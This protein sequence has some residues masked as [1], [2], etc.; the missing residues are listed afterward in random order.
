MN[1]KDIAAIKLGS[2]AFTKK[3]WQ[4]HRGILAMGSGV[5]KALDDWQRYCPA[6]P[7]LIDGVAEVEV[8]TETC[9]RLKAAL[10]RAKKKCGKL[11]K[12]TGLAC[13]AYIAEIDKYMPKLGLG[14]TE[15]SD[16]AAIWK[17]ILVAM[18]KAIGAMV[19]M[20][21]R[22]DETL[23]ALGKLEETA[24]Y[25]VTRAKARNMMPLSAREDLE[26]AVKELRA[27]WG[28]A[29][30]FTNREAAGITRLADPVLDLEGQLKTRR[31][32]KDMRALRD[33][34]VK[35]GRKEGAL[36]DR[37]TEVHLRIQDAEAL[38]SQSQ[39]TVQR[40]KDTLEQYM[41]R[42]W[43]S[44]VGSATELN[45]TIQDLTARLAKIVKANVASLDEGAKRDLSAEMRSIDD[46]RLQLDSNVTNL[47]NIV[48]TAANDTKA[49]A[50]DKEIQAKIKEMIAAHKMIATQAKKLDAVIRA[51]SQKVAQM[52]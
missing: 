41:T 28:E 26:G 23:A 32:D 3:W 25:L 45:K 5:G 29:D 50:Q 8:A 36:R 15:D 46:E 38:I 20:E 42:F 47:G 9:N 10:E 21:K 11:D 27:S 52:A 1:R 4:D 49:F 34:I 24:E 30:R 13:D 40:A 14:V 17:K 39:K 6:R 12:E 43:D 35:A 48:K 31:N 33:M 44:P 37:L 18:P 51:A 7:E 16:D 19:N 2:V 22:I